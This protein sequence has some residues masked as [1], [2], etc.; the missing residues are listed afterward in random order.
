MK[1]DNFPASHNSADIQG[2]MMFI[3]Q[4]SRI[5]QIREQPDTFQIGNGTHLAHSGSGHLYLLDLRCRNGIG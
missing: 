3:D 2:M 5:N 1:T 4:R